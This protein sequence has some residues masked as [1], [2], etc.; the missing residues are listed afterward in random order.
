SIRINPTIWS[1]LFDSRRF[2]GYSIS[3]ILR[4]TL[5]WEMQEMGRDI[6]PLIPMPEIQLQDV[7]STQ[8]LQEIQSYVYTK[9][10]DYEPRKIFSIF[11]DQFY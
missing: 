11:W 2:L 8:H 3:A 9:T 4:I 7:D 5:D 10:A 6:I 1:K